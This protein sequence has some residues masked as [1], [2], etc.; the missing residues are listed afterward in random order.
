MKKGEKRVAHEKEVKIELLNQ[1]T[2][3][4]GDA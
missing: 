3:K 1:E 2:D 4:N